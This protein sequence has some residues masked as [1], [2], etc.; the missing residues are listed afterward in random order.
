MHKPNLVAETRKE[1][2]T[3]PSLVYAVA[4]LFVESGAKVL[5]TESPGA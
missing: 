2:A 1:A 4:R 5:I 3:H